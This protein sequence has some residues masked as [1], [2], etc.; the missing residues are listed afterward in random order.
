MAAM[1]VVTDDEAAPEQLAAACRVLPA[2][3]PGGAS[4]RIPPDRERYAWLYDDE[5][6]WAVVEEGAP[7]EAGRR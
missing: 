5:D 3:T 2:R 7:P 4:P 6:I 1:I